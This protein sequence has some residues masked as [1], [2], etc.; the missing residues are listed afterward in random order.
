MVDPQLRLEGVIRG[1]SQVVHRA[2]SRLQHEAIHDYAEA[3][4]RAREVSARR[5]SLLC[6]EAAGGVLCVATTPRAVRR[7]PISRCGSQTHEIVGSLMSSK[8][9]PH[10]SVAQNI[11]TKEHVLANVLSCLLIQT[12][13][14]WS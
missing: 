9:L 4:R 6:G 7:V 12:A 1:E 10:D 11:I 8:P 5:S 14:V 2:E 13:V 3:C